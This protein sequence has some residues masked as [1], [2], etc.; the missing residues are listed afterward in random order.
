MS[1]AQIF[2]TQLCGVLDELAESIAAT[3]TEEL[4]FE[5]LLKND[6]APV[7]LHRVAAG[8]RDK[9]QIALDQQ[10]FEAALGVPGFEAGFS[11][12]KRVGA[13]ETI[14]S[15]RAVPFLSAT[16]SVG[17]TSSN[18]AFETLTTMV[19]DAAEHQSQV[20]LRLAVLGDIGAGKRTLTAAIKRVFSSRSSQFQS[21]T[22]AA[23][24]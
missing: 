3:P 19:D 17:S 20:P 7:D 14:K 23:K 24:R 2:E 22:E 1:E 11:V 16:T 18:H 15:S 13:N 21:N 9:F 5:E 4:D 8:V 12:E 6:G 10:R